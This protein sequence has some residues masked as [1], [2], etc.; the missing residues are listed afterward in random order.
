MARIQDIRDLEQRITDAVE[1]YLECPEDYTNPVL[2]ISRDN[3]TG[4]YDASVEDAD[5]LG[6]DMYPIDALLRNEY[7]DLEPDCDEIS[8]VA[9]RFLF[10]D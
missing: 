7:G 3:V 10:L 6:E 2:A 8:E 9:N 4:L 1:E 5:E